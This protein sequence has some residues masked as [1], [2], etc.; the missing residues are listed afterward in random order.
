MPRSPL[1]AAGVLLA[2]LAILVL[3][4]ENRPSW[5]RLRKISGSKSVPGEAVSS[6]RFGRALGELGLLHPVP[7]GRRPDAPAQSL[8]PIP[9]RR[10][11]TPDQ[12]TLVRMRRRHLRASY[13]LR[14]LPQELAE[15]VPIVSVLVPDEQLDEIHSVPF[16]R[17]RE[18]ERAAFVGIFEKGELVVGQGAGVRIHGGASRGRKS[19]R[20]YRLS[21]RRSYGHPVFSPAPFL[22]ARQ[23][24]IKELVLRA[25]R[26]WD[27]HGH[28]WFFSSPLAMDLARRIGVETPRSRPVLFMLN[29]SYE[30]VYELT[31]YLGRGFVE[32]RYGLDD[33]ALVR[34]KQNKYESGS[35][36]KHGPEQPYEELLEYA[37]RFSRGDTRDRAGDRVSLESLYRWVVAVTFVDTRDQ[38]QGAL[39]RDLADPGARWFWIAWDLELSFGV[40]LLPTQQPWRA[41]SLAIML[42]TGR[43]DPRRW[44]FQGL[45]RSPEQ[46]RR[47]VELAVEALNHRMTTAFLEERLAFYREQARLFGLE[48]QT[49]LDELTDYLHNRP[50]AYRQHLRTAFDQPPSRQVRITGPPKSQ[51]EIDGFPTELPWRGEYFDGMI[52]RLA[53]APGTR[54]SIDGDPR[55]IGAAPLEIALRADLEIELLASPGESTQGASERSATIRHAPSSSINSRVLRTTSE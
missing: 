18:S 39:V 34:T 35:K 40:S 11:S 50:T 33:F 54:L 24:P 45:M 2:V 47:F 14:Q 29:G 27:R 12:L 7:R 36:V 41:D 44:L 21:A 37:R 3:V 26:G 23:Q 6:T 17:G 20:G 43:V 22:Q 10:G 25:N 13:K 42:K 55:T 48:D 15:T 30:G 49:F 31:E 52:M 38:F 46:R 5:Q 53:A 4:A 19:W 28:P 16:L 9:A 8:G 32:I 1:T 51:L